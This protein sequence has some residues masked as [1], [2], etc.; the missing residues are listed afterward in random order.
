MSGSLSS[1]GHIVT[2]YSFESG[3]GRTM[4]LANVAWILA[5]NGKR[6]LAVDW[7][8]ESPGLHHYFRPFLTDPK[9]CQS[10]G[11]IDL[12]CDFAAG[13]V[14]PATPADRPQWYQPYA[15]VEREAVSLNWRFPNNGSL[16]LLPAGVQDTAYSQRVST[17]DWRNFYDRLNGETF[18]RAIRDSMRRH[19]DYVLIDSRTGL[20]N[21][22]RICTVIMPDTVV[23]CFTL[24][25]QSIDGAAALAEAIHGQRSNEAVRILPVP[26]RV[27]AAEQLKLKAGRD[28]A[29]YRFGSH[30]DAIAA[31]V[32][33]FWGDVEIPY[34]PFFAYKEI[35]AVFGERSRQEHSLLSSFERL[36]GVITSNEV[37]ECPAI[38]E[39]ERRRRLAQYERQ[40]LLLPN[41][42]VISYAS[43]NRSWADWIANELENIGLRVTLRKVDLTTREAS[44]GDPDL[45]TW[46]DSAT[47]VLTLLSRDYVG[48]AN[49]PAIWQAV[50]AKNPG[51]TALVPVRLD[52]TRLPAPFAQQPP[53]LDLVN[54]SEERARQALL[55]TF[56]G[57][58]PSGRRTTS[59]HAP[60]FPSGQ[61]PIWEVPQRN[62]TFTGRSEL[63][64]CL[65]DR[66][67]ADVTVVIPQALHGL[68]GVG[69]TQ[70]ALEYA[71]RFAV[72]YDIVW[73]ISAE[74]P[75]LVRSSLAELA[76]ELELPTGGD[77]GERVDTVLDTLRLGEPYQRWL[78]VFDNAGD[79]ADLERYL[80][81]GPGHTVITTRDAGWARRATTIEV[82]VFSRAESVALLQRRVPT[83]S[84][85][86]ADMLAEK[87]GDLPLVIEQ[88]GALLAVTGMPVETYNELLDSRLAEV[89]SEN[90]PPSCGVPAAVTWRLSMDRLRRQMPAAAKL[91][92]VCAFLAAEPIPISF[93]YNE[94]FIEVLLPM[95][96]LLSEPLVQGRL[97]QEIG[98]Y[99]LARIDSGQS[100]IQLHPL[101]RAV[102][103]DGLPEDEQQ[104][105]RRHVH[106]ILAGLNPRDPD[107]TN[108][109]RTYQQLHRHLEA[110]GA[111]GS[112]IPAVRQLVIDLVRYLWK[113][114]D[115]Q[116]SQ[117]LG[118]ATL[119][120]WKARHGDAAADVTTLSL[121]LHLAN[122][123][124]SL[125]RYEEAF[126]ADS[127][128][129][130]EL[131]RR[132]GADHPYAIMATSSLA[133]DLR[134]KGRYA[135]ARDLDEQGLA[136]STEVLGQEHYRTT[137]AMNNLALSLALV[138]DFQA[139]AALDEQALEIRR[140]TQGHR[141]RLI[142]SSVAALG[143]DYRDLGRFSEAQ[144]LL[145]SHLPI[146]QE[147]LGDTHPLTLRIIRT[148]AVTL[149]KAGAIEAAYQMTIE[150]LPRHERRLGSLHPDT[151]ACSSNLACNQSAIGDDRAARATAEDVLVRCRTKVGEDHPFLLS[152]ENNLAI[153]LRRLGELDAAQPVAQRV[154]DRLSATLG[155]D[156]PYTLA[157]RI[158]LA[159][160][161]YDLRDY[162]AA[163]AV[164]LDV[165]ERINRS[166]GP[167]HPDSLAAENNL[168][169]SLRRTGPQE[170]ADSLAGGVLHRAYRVLGLEHPNSAAIRNG[171]RLNCDIDPPQF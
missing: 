11:V 20:S 25:D 166:L 130:D 9:L 170:Q 157:C 31:D 39:R 115:H 164:D 59:R 60:R 83:L 65:R 14:D 15:D 2:F 82:G 138:G 111:L 162:A 92:E 159:N 118:E 158:N 128:V 40:N 96:P 152:G 112:T 134:A 142:L 41:D 171:T 106:E 126:E 88:A 67:S 123:T 91:L 56:D 165:R 89:L 145:S 113:R 169:I 116:A 87:L 68:G 58:A 151:I 85:P 24:N 13:V 76:E 55:G 105:N 78:L 107:D 125:A 94:R 137:N 156:H 127:M 119:V 63:L 72:D 97:V 10:R 150:A 7:D 57:L 21:S 147:E 108:H 93:F 33:A 133:A 26:M 38:D 104:A 132:L 155:P 8:L 4:A 75:N 47:R 136:L 81:Q 98:R 69:K 124:R 48:S 1:H 144:E 102:I 161:L 54:M 73:W 70:I 6:V 131:T 86:Q 36:S 90:P 62:A 16:D 64:A 27:E 18:L 66:L 95:D 45:H 80:P 143:R 34:K 146:A 61:P 149:R 168:A 37:R 114:G 42:V 140:R 3:T 50:A 120:S 71:H 28:Y 29:R 154:V 23:D 19:Y 139:A 103:R 153:F 148:L 84:A 121:R 77:L 74:Q 160:Q 52:D 43:V 49:A 17:F 35:L 12:M 100:T 79:P 53:T 167:D 135:E 101:V 30:L 129:R 109:W 51:G 22:A 117:Q 5:A 141:H 46:L 122:A 99:A 44:I 32:D 163:L 110:S